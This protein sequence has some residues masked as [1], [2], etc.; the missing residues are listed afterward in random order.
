MDNS[1][2]FSTLQLSATATS[3]WA[4]S[5][6]I[7]PKYILS[8]ES[9]APGNRQ[10][11]CCP[12]DL[13]VRDSSYQWSCAACD[14]LWL[15]SFT[16]YIVFEVS[17]IFWPVSVL[18]FF[19]QLKIFHCMGIPQFVSFSSSVDR[20]LGSFHL[21][22]IV[23]STALINVHVQFLFECLFSIILYICPR[24]KLPGCMVSVC[25]IF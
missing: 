2:T 18:H 5:I 17:S 6:F 23:N 13:P 24:A 12:L 22:V 21:L 7:N 16:Q 25:L 9:P 3:V 11:A 19:L 1:V 15:A 14:L 8:N 4:Q 10:S 20:H